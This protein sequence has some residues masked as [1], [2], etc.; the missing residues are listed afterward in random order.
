V[1]QVHR[2]YQLHLR[3]RSRKYRLAEELAQT[4]L[5]DYSKRDWTYREILVRV[6]E[7]RVSEALDVAD[8][9]AK[10]MSKRGCRV[11]R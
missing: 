1:E 2:A 11:W 8:L 3:L 10:C 4:L 7:L 9:V 5:E 6:R